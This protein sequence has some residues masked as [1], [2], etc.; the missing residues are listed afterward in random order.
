M[1]ARP[2]GRLAE[3]AA[4]ARARSTRCD[5]LRNMAVPL[6]DQIWK[7][8]MFRSAWLTAFMF[9]FMSSTALAQTAWESPKSACK[10][11]RIK[12]CPTVRIGGA[13][14]NCLTS[15]SEQLSEGCRKALGVK[16]KADP[17]SRIR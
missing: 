10:D 1:I 7:Q 4:A 15:Q 8:A 17:W 3:P 11:D 9:A 16:E 14:V 6:G 12:L 13:V 5:D 2:N